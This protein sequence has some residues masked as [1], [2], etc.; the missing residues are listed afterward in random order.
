MAELPNYRI[1]RDLPLMDVEMFTDDRI[2]DILTRLETIGFDLH[3]FP[4]PLEN[5]T[6]RELDMLARETRG[7][8]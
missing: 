3:R 5:L 1:V 7:A 8:N 4:N 6:L 2:A